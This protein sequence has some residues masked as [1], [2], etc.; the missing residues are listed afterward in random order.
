M[1]AGFTKIKINDFR[2]RK[3]LKKKKT[4]LRSRNSSKHSIINTFPI[5][6]KAK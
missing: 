6:A 3:V 5:T 4:K 2:R 1:A